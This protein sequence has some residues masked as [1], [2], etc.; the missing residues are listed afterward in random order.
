MNKKY[1]ATTLIL[2]ILS[3]TGCHF[4]AGDTND[5]RNPPMNKTVQAPPSF[6]CNKAST[7]VEKLICSDDELAKLDVE[8]TSFTN[9]INYNNKQ[10]IEALEAKDIKKIKNIIGNKKI[11]D[12]SKGETSPLLNLVLSSQNESDLISYLIK[13]GAVVNIPNNSVNRSIQMATPVL[14]PLYYVVNYQKDDSEI[15]NTKILLKHG[16]KIN[17]QAYW[18]MTIINVLGCNDINI[19]QLKLFH[20]NGLD[21][22]LRTGTR[23][24]FG[25]IGENLLMKFIADGISIDNDDKICFP[26]IE[27]LLINGIDINATQEQG[28]SALFYLFDYQ[29]NIQN[30]ISPSKVLQLTNLLINYKIDVSI[31]NNAGYTALWYLENNKYLKSSKEYEAIRKLLI[32]NMNKEVLSL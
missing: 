8:L 23:D 9:T 11:I 19:K 3:I 14:S 31:R 12:A 16:A 4:T 7:E 21:L 20:E 5:H 18:G 24:N 29:N 6:D 25:D 30:K 15:N 28:N 32:T 26:A 27:Y 17:F 1:Y 13:H 10:L 22:N 2:G